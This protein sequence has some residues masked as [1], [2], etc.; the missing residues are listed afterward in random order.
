MPLVNRGANGVIRSVLDDFV[1]DDFDSSSAVSR[2][3]YLQEPHAR[4]LARSMIPLAR[5]S[6]D[7]TG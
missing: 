4:N 5:S 6:C 2:R 7:K 1:A 3:R